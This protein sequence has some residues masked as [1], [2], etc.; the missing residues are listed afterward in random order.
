MKKTYVLGVVIAR[1]GSKGLPGKN[2]A[3]LGQYSLLERAIMAARHAKTLDRVILSTDSPKMAK[4]G[5]KVGAEVPFLRPTHLAQDKT[6]TPDVIAHAVAFIE[7]R[8]KKRVD[9]VVTLQPTSPFRRAE[10]IDAVVRLLL[11]HKKFDSA[12]SVKSSAFPP[13]WMLRAQK[14]RLSPLFDDGTDYSL[15]E[16]QQ[17]P[18]TFQ[19]NG[20]VYATRRDLLMK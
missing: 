19:P 5:K 11:K 14:N 17:L 13:H 10:H 9:I 18:Q 6:H 4:Q 2:L 15:K 8:D 7:K 3:K 1:G 20:A 16:R 12:I